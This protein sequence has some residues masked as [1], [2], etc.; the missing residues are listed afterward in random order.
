MLKDHL[1]GQKWT[2]DH[3]RAAL[4]TGLVVA[5]VAILAFAALAAWVLQTG[6]LDGSLTPL[7]SALHRQALAAPAWQVS[8]WLY[9]AAL[10]QWV[11]I[12]LAVILGLLW[13]FNKMWRELLMLII[14]VAGGS[15]WF[16]LLTQTFGRHRP[17]FA[18][19]I[20]IIDF[21]GFPSGHLISSTTFYGLMLY[22][23]ALKPARPRW[24]WAISI[25]IVLILVLI[26]Y[27]RLFLG[28]HYLTDVLAGFIVGL[29]WAA[30]V[31]P[32]V[33]WFAARKKRE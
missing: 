24:R 17:I 14:G 12:A 6:P 2:L 29:A 21:P 27:S 9:I 3:P 30:I 11:I 7:V 28:D 33:D 1:S 8:F 26:G 25:A 22:L 15:G 5:L 13:L 4:T 31:Y 18:Q 32:V 19:P 20:H 23:Y 16:L 10:G